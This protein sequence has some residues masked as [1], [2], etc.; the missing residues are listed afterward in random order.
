MLRTSLAFCLI[1]ATVIGPR[2]RAVVLYY[3]I[4][5]TGPQRTCHHRTAP[6]RPADRAGADT[7]RSGHRSHGR[8]TTGA[9]RDRGSLADRRLQ[10]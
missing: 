4:L 2:G 6:A 10:Q 1:L 3:D 7:D 5:C 9:V 8:P